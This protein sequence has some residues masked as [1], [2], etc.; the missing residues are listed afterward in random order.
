MAGPWQHESRV[1]GQAELVQMAGLFVAE[2]QNGTCAG[3]KGRP[4]MHRGKESC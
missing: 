4:C 2:K 3:A 1:G